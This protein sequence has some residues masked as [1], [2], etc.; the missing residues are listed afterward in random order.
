MQDLKL[1]LW[2]VA[3]LLAI[4]LTTGC[5]LS[6]SQAAEIISNLS[7]NVAAQD[8][9]CRYQA[10]TGKEHVQAALNNLAVKIKDF[11]KWRK[12]N[13][14]KYADY[15]KKSMAKDCKSLIETGKSYFIS[16]DVVNVRKKPTLK[17]PIN[18]QVLQNQKVQVVEL[19]YIPKK[20]SRW[21]GTWIKVKQKKRTGWVLDAFLSPVSLQT[22][23]NATAD[24]NN[25][26]YHY[27]KKKLYLA[28][29]GLAKLSLT[30]NLQGLILMY[31]KD[32]KEYNINQIKKY[33]T[34]SYHLSLSFEMGSGK[35]ESAFLIFDGSDRLQ[36]LFGEPDQV[37]AKLK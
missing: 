37:L 12:N 8:K 33:K 9:F 20:V 23:L 25:E 3:A 30:E 2:P 14:K 5:H 27:S 29:A 4:I 15:L 13:K 6:D 19:G 18:F 10:F 28:P 17:S 22:K 31:T 16:G 21:L 11:K 24:K 34:S 1:N 7:Q 26:M 32:Q 35:Q 36:L